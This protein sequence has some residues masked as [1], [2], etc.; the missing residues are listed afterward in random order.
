M[1]DNFQIVYHYLKI[2]ELTGLVWSMRYSSNFSFNSLFLKKVRWVRL[3]S[4][5]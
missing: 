4:Y 1:S 3:K 5:V 2:P